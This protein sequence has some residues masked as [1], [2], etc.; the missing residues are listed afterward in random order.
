[1]TRHNKSKLYAAILGALA[2]FSTLATAADPSFHRW[3]MSLRQEALAQGI[4]SETLD[5]A[6]REIRPIPRVIELDCKQPE[7][8]LTFQEY[9][10]RAVPESRIADGREKLRQHHAQLTAIGQRYG[11]QPRF[12][13][14]LW[15]IESDY[16]RRM[17]NFPVI[18]ALATLAHDGRRSTYFRKELLHALHILDDGHISADQMIGSW[19]GAM[20]QSQFMPS[21]FRRYAVDRDGDGRRDIW[22]SRSDVFA[23]IANYLA[24]LG[25]RG[26][27]T[28][29]REV[30]LPEGF[31]PK[32]I[33]LDQRKPLAEWRKLGVRLADGRE[34]PA[35][36]L[37]ASLV[38]PDDRDGRVFAVYHN[39]RVVMRWNRS[40]YF[41]TAVGLLADRIGN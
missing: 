20:G 3:L 4:A 22:G 41:A 9:L 14:A 32:L 23:S 12:I 16:G 7:F 25:W 40:T 37:L 10:D 39:Y 36:H 28:W 29:G 13:V 15:G 27:E 1:V 18:A 21:S 19:A 24:R 8:V 5:H 2:L 11:V 34:L 38:Q 31:N 35:R 33:D 30:R 6:L 26:D 17:G